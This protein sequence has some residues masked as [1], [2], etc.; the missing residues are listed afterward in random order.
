MAFALTGRVANI[1]QCTQGDALG[2]ERTGLSAHLWINPKL[3]QLY[4]HCKY[5]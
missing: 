1:S 5:I 2:Y 4:L 3:E